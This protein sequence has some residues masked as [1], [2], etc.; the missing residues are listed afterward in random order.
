M[1]RPPAYQ[2]YANDLLALFVGLS[3]AALGAVQRIFLVM[4]SQAADHSSLVDDDAMLT[5]PEIR[6]VRQMVGCGGI[7]CG[8]WHAPCGW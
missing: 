3:L 5:V 6:Q 8:G 1:T 4:W 2:T 7:R